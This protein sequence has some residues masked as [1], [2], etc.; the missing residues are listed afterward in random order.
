MNNLPP[1]I[2]F[3][4]M[5][6]LSYRDLLSISKTCR[7]FAQLCQ[8]YTFWL[9]KCRYDFSNTM[10]ILN[11][12]KD[13]SGHTLYLYLLTQND[14]EIGSEK[15]IDLDTCLQRAIQKHDSFLVR[16]F[17]Q[18]GSE[19][20]CSLIQAA[21]LGHFDV[22]E[23]LYYHLFGSNITQVTSLRIRESGKTSFTLRK[24]YI[25]RM[26]LLAAGSSKSLS[27]SK[28]TRSNSLSRNTSNGKIFYLI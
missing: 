15:F 1:E 16:Y 13:L 6:Y 2:L 27:R 12:K 18:K 5:I 11:K 23:Y 19:D 4:I 25:L 22:V 7:H 21:K 8:D 26:A 17:T 28:S 10:D 3:S 20:G 9:N 24:E 14:C